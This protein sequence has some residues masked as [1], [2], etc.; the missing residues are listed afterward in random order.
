MS[1][2]HQAIKDAALIAILASIL[3]VQQIALSFL[4]NV[5]FTTL[6]IVLYARVIGFKKTALI[7]VLHVA[8]I[9]ILSPFGPVI[10]MHIPS[11]LIAWLLIPF[12]LHTVFKKA[13]STWALAI[14]GLF[15]G[16][17]YGW[18]FIPVSVFILDIPFLVY[19]YGDLLFEIIMAVTNFLTILWL[20]EPLKKMLIE[21][22]S[23]YYM[24]IYQPKN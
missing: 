23:R 24:T 14:F 3:F 16:F 20:Y 5:Q 17:L 6:L 8:A 13:N 11:M 7:V 15:F 10:P 18:L 19:F 1:K 21:Q 12:L 4:P 22:K 2:K 9:N